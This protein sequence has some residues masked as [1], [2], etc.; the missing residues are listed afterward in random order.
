M[1]RWILSC[2]SFNRNFVWF[3][4]E[5]KIAPTNIGAILA[6]S[7]FLIEELGLDLLGDDFLFRDG[8]LG[9]D[10]LGH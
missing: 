6:V 7:A 4:V 10:L 5:T 1:W 8:L 9:D 3:R 2:G